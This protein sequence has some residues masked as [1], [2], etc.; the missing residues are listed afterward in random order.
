[1]S[2]HQTPEPAGAVIGT[3]LTLLVLASTVAWALYTVLA[4]PL[5]QRYSSLKVTGLSM[6]AGT[7]GIILAAAPE[8]QRQN[9]GAVPWQ[10]WSGIAYS[11]VLAVSLS[12]V[13]WN[14]GIKIVGSA[15][16]AIYGNLQ[17]VAAMSIGWLW[18]GEGLGWWQVIG[19]AVIVSGVFL[20]RLGTSQTARNVT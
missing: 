7:P 12:Y 11:A 18:L 16:T 8:W 20:T 1:M 6:L 15:R 17:P 4:R 13:V 14:A 9:W 5:L 3:I 2:A 19:A 10:G